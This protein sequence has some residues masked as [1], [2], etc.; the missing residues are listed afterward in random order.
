M[1]R[2]MHDTLAQG[3]TGI[4]LQL[5][6]AEQ[7]LN[8]NSPELEGHLNQARSLA[9]KSLAEARRSVWNLRPEALEQLPLPDALGQEVDRFTRE[10][11]VTA[12]FILRGD[13]RELPPEMEAG[14]LRICQ[15]SLANVKKH[16]KASAVEVDLTFDDSAVRLTISDD[17]VGFR[18]ESLSKASKKRRTFGFTSMQ[19]RARGLGGMFDVQT[20]KGKGT[21][22]RVVIPTN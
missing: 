2:E 12:S 9:R 21:L 1:A 4:I 19:E 7:A 11:G 15:E 20:K 6:A 8:D 18:P 17:G 13:S 5:E 16:A 22:V 14:L 3:F 10:V